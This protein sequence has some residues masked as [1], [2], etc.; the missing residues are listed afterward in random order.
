MTQTPSG[1]RIRQWLREDEARMA[2]LQVLATVAPPDAWLA[3]GFVRNLVWD[4]LH[5]YSVPTPLNDLDVIYFDA[6]DVSRP[7]EQAFE[8]A[9]RARLDHPWSVRNQARM[10]RRNGDRPYQDSIDAMCYWVEVETA[11]AVRLTRADT[12]QLAAPFG[13]ESLMAGRVTPNPYR[14]RPE[15][16]ARRWHEKGW[17]QQWPLLSEYS[18]T[19]S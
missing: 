11:V 8:V 10:H 14:P 7:T 15:A 5:G 4:R 1:V 13:L 12:L 19:S 2:A 18:P 9:L 3:A 6:V 17:L 16:F